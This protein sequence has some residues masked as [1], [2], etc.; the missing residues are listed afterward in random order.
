MKILAFNEGNL[1]SHIMGQGQLEQA[2]RAGRAGSGAEVEMGFVTLAPMGRQASAA[3]NWQV[4]LLR[5]RRLD[6]TQLRWHLVQSLRAR[7]ALEEALGSTSADIVLVHTPAVSLAMGRLMA[8]HPV[9]LSMDTTIADW[10]EMPA[11][12]ETHGLAST[13][14]RPSRALERRSLERAAI[15]LAW[16]PWAQR[17]AAAE[18]PRARVVAHHPGIDIERYRPAP[19]DPR[20]R[21]RVLFV[22][23]R[24]PEKGG[25]DLLEALA[26]RLGDTVELDIVSPAEVP[27]RP[28]LRVH[29]LEPSDER[30]LRL[31]QQADVFCLPSHGDAAPWAVLEAMACGTAVVASTVGGIPDLL[32]EGE[33]GVLVP[34]G[35]PGALSQALFSL[36]DD[37]ARRDAT[38]G[39]AR[40]RVERDYDARRQF[41]R[42]T[43]LL[44]GV[45]AD[46]PETRRRSTTE[47]SRGS[48]ARSPTSRA[49]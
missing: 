7:S 18:A 12:R 45:L 22:G 39:A 37:P 30:L 1:G 23:G 13:L 27:E 20:A 4:P 43:A 26:G 42:M 19:R 31:H 49:G 40:A 14:I 9:V 16:T 11:W 5:H 17:A 35:R 29:R 6:L 15:V 34:P 33:A 47:S 3:A 2:L 48:T 41:T 21:S 8:E 32:G 38:A 24:F 25:L 44:E 28:G 36:L 10:A 46:Q